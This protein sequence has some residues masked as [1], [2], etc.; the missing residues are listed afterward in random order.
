[1]PASLHDGCGQEITINN[2]SAATAIAGTTD[3]LEWRGDE[4]TFQR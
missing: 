2:S 1:M 4:A 3:L